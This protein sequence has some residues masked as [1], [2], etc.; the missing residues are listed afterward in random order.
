MNVH[1]VPPGRPPCQTTGEARG[2]YWASSRAWRWIEGARSGIDRCGVDTF[3][4]AVLETAIERAR[5]AALVLDD[6]DGATSTFAEACRKAD[7]EYRQRQ[8]RLASRP[9][10]DTPRL[11][12]S[13]IAAVDY[14]LRQ[15]DPRALQN[16]VADHPPSQAIKIIAYAKGRTLCQ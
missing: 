6:C 14:L 4:Q 12:V 10:R 1:V 5:Q 16:F 8:E 3:C 15:D 11:A 9:V 2:G 13:T 7:A